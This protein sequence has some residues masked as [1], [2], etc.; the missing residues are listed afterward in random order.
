MQ[1]EFD[2]ILSGRI[3]EVF[4]NYEDDSASIGWED[5]Q[6]RLPEKKNKK[7]ALLWWSS[8]A[9]VLALLLTYSYYS[10]QPEPVYLTARAK[11]TEVEETPAKTTGRREP[12][13]ALA[14]PAKGTAPESIQTA[15]TTAERS[16]SKRVPAEPAI[17]AASEPLNSPFAAEPTSPVEG[18]E[19]SALA[20]A[21]IP[22][23][24]VLEPNSVISPD[25]VEEVLAAVPPSPQ[26]EVPLELPALASVN[27]KTREASR[28]QKGISIG[29]FA[30][31]YV[32]YSKGSETNV[33]TGFGLM[34][35]I[36]LSKK[37]KLSTGV[38]L[39]QNTLT[40]DVEIPQSA[41]LSFAE[42]TTVSEDLGLWMSRPAG[43]TTYNINT[44]NASLLGL[45]IPINLKYNFSER[46]T[47]LYMVAG[48]SSNFFLSESYKY[49]YSINDN[50]SNTS[51]EQLED[52]AQTFNFAR[53]L[54]L[55]VGYERPL[56]K[57]NRLSLEPFLKYPLGGLGSQN[58]RF[59]SAGLNL[60]MSLNPERRK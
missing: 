29:V 46:T 20:T 43:Q 21:A 8:A 24:T 38:A 59:G 10:F 60:K 2:R 42:K 32:N 55:S 39:A 18:P 3:K 49:S 19:L 23:A 44:Y 5:L 45:D 47:T 12:I 17:P 36:G 4:D 57:Q 22:E 35:E 11:K 50:R 58:I 25:R 14:A 31:S 53:M 13:I 34:S 52:E 16:I 6:R 15:S 54:N 37:L 56:G 33:N 48:L 30:G 27:K 51:N 41:A 7:P 9:A 26:K 1:D 40:Y 28:Q